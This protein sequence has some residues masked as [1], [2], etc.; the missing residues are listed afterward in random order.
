MAKARSKAASGLT[1]IGRDLL[2][3][4]ISTIESDSI[5]GRKM[6]WF[7]HAVIDVLSKYADWLGDVGKV[8][9]ERI[10]GL[11]KPLTMEALVEMAGGGKPK[12]VA[13]TNGLKHIEQLRLTAKMIADHEWVVRPG[14]SPL[15]EVDRGIAHRI[16]RN[17]DQMKAMVVRFRRVEPWRPYL[18]TQKAQCILGGT[19]LASGNRRSS[20]GGGHGDSAEFGE[21]DEGLSR[22]QIAASVNAAVGNE[23]EP[24]LDSD[25]ATRLRKI[26]ELG[27][28][29]VVAQTIVH[30]DGDTVTRVQGALGEGERAYLLE[31]HHQ[32]V[33]TAMRQWKALFDVFVALVGGVA[34]QLFGGRR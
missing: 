5:T 11:E 16:R 21:I 26:W 15:K 19:G 22:V 10:L 17:C 12:G 14:G 8:D 18:L 31:I 27:T 1:E 13:I 25:S 9:V 3:M 29:V 4:E 28:D 23:P 34:S 20:P 30:I 7:P 24:V 6:P 2:A 33:A 32:A